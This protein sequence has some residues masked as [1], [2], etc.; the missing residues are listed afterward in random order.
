MENIFL[1][2]IM[3]VSDNR[4]WLGPLVCVAIW[5]GALWVVVD[6]LTSAAREMKEL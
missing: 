4:R 2:S 1:N 3:W 5:A 6:V